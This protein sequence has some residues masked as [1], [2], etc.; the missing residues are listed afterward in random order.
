M[1]Q[2]PLIN[3]F[4]IYGA[5]FI[6]KDKSDWYPIY[7]LAEPGKYSADPKTFEEELED[8]T[9]LEDLDS[10]QYLMQGRVLNEKY[11]L[12]LH[13]STRTF[14]IGINKYYQY[15][16][17]CSVTQ[18]PVIPLEEYQRLIIFLNTYQIKAEFKQIG[19]YIFNDSV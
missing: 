1:N 10:Y 5:P 7:Q 13:H 2:L 3:C 15:L 14:Y 4:M 11:V 8:L 12:F 6:W 16:A 19:M 18:V 9:F 17:S